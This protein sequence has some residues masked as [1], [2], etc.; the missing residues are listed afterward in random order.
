MKLITADRL[1]LAKLPTGKINT[2]CK[3]HLS[4]H[5]AVTISLSSYCRP[6][7]RDSYSFSYL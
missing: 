6:I 2:T 1:L 4:A 5:C 7:E 3:Q